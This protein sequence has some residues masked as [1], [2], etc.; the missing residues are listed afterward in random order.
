MKELPVL[1]TADNRAKVRRGDKTQTRRV[2]VPQP[3]STEMCPVIIVGDVY[4]PS[5]YSWHSDMYGNVYLKARYAVGDH[6]WMLE[7][8]QIL[9]TWYNKKA[10]EGVYLDGDPTQPDDPFSADGKA[11]LFSDKEWERYS[12]RKWPHRKTSSRFMYKS[13]A[14]TWVEVTDVRRERVRDISE[15]DAKAEGIESHWDG[16]Q[17]WYKNYL[18]SCDFNGYDGAIRS[19]ETLWDSIN[20]KRGFGRDVNPWVLVYGLKLIEKESR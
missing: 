19:Y 14:R 18:G 13:L 17:M 3:I 9:R 15:A 4:S 12:K 7:P 11:I 10:V 6:L 2:I 8:Y 16:S 1:F 20:K 5:G